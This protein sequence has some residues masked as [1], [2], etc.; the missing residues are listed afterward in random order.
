MSSTNRTLVIMA[1]APRL[2]CVKTRLAENVSLEAVTDLY[3]CLLNDTIAL[4]QT[5]NHVE[6]AIMCPAADVEDLSRTVANSVPIVAQTGEG[7][8]AGLD[9]VF[10]HFVIDGHRV[11]AFNSDSPHLPALVLESAF[12]ALA[13]CD[14]VVG[15]THDGG[16]YLVGARAFHPGLFVN[17]TMGTVNAFNALLARARGLGLS[18]F[19]TPRFYDVDIAEDLHQLAAEL[20]RTPARAPRTAAWL[21]DRARTERW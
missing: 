8:A 20:K 4:A 3:L 6:I 10:A 13:T 15:P 21:L 14:L 11:I 9:S 1:K 18:T 12:D 19:L 5:L 16:Y 2:G 17:D 7:L